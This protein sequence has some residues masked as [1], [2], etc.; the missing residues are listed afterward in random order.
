[1]FETNYIPFLEAILFE[2]FGEEIAV[3]SFQFI[4]GGCINNA[5]KINTIK[6]FFFLK[7]NESDA[8]VQMFETEAKGLQLLSDTAC[9]RIPNIL[10]YGKNENKAYLLLEFITPYFRGENYWSIL[11]EQLA[12][13]H[14]N[15]FF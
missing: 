13:L 10:S 7:W 4:G 12:A 5:L 11:G 9:V 15:N 2:S 8:S 1:M 6:G 14:K 3:D